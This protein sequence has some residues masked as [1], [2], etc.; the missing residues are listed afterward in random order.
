ME[1]I[2]EILLQVHRRYSENELLKAMENRIKELEFQVG[3][4]KSERDEL[5]Y[6]IHHAKKESRTELRKD[7]YVQNL[8]KLN[9]AQQKLKIKYRN[10]CELWRNKYLSLKTTN[11]PSF[12]S[13]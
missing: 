4:L 5:H 8:L 12:E 10:D 7:E 9:K 13:A 6:K 1:E 3:E 11:A 2:K